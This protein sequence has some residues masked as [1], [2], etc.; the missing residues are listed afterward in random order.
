MEFSDKELEVT[1]L[2]KENA[3]KCKEHFLTSVK[4][5]RFRLPFGFRFDREE[6]HEWSCLLR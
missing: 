5:H 6:L 3:G 2:M 1:V 4:K